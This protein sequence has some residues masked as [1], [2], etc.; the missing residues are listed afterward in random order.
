MSV[1]KLGDHN[2]EAM[3]KHAPSPCVVMFSSAGC[4]LCDAL[5][6]IFREVS[7]QYEDKFYFF[8]VNTD[9]SEKLREK[10]S[11]DG[12][13][14]MRV[15][16]SE[17]FDVGHEIPYPGDGDSGYTKQSLVDYINNFKRAE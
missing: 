5:K 7:K 16:R 1:Y 3:V 8:N 17:N 11:D 13:P 6:P 9:E 2:F 15:F 10:Y 14:T 4:H 12:V